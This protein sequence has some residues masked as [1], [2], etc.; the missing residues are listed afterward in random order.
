MERMLRVAVTACLALWAGCVFAA[1]EAG[2]DLAPDDDVRGGGACVVDSDCTLAGPSCCEC[3]TFAVSLESRWDD[4]CEQ[5]QCPAMP[6]D[7]PA[8]VAL[9]DDGVCA[10]ACEPAACDISCPTG[11]AVDAAGCTTCECAN[12]GAVPSCAVD[13]DCVRVPADCCGCDRGGNDTAVPATVRDEFVNGLGCS[14]NESCP[15]VSTCNPGD[16]PHC[17]GGQCMLGGGSAPPPAGECGRP[18]LPPCPDGQVCVI[19]AMDSEAGTGRCE[20]P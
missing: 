5:V 11:F 8:L 4:T 16:A 10:A 15:G 20:A 13:T 17:V 18:D 3:P 1:N 14:G 19:N 7:C 12:G 6:A 9:C 2:G